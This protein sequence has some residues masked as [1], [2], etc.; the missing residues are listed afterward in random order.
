MSSIDTEVQPLSNTF[1]DA[2]LHCTAVVL[3]YKTV[4][5]HVAAQLQATICVQNGVS[6]LP[7]CSQ[8]MQAAVVD[9]Q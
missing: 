5:C 4:H 9:S 2:L 8:T 6:V 3:R 7:S 1:N